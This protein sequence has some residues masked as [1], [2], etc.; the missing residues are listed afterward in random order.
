MKKP[1]LL[2]LIA[3]LTANAAATVSAQPARSPATTP[4]TA[5][6]KLDTAETLKETTV[7]AHAP[8]IRN[9]TEKKVF[10]VNQSLV[11]T[12]GSAAD[13]LQNVPTLQLDGNG[14]LSL[15]GATDLLLLV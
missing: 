11:S 12:G 6:G 1:G 13:L 9:G 3:A 8:T 2:L 7:I 5:K 14:N 4:D 15:R 10:S